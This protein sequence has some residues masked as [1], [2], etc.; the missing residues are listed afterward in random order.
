MSSSSTVAL[1]APAPGWDRQQ[2]PSAASCP[3]LLLRTWPPAHPQSW[4][5]AAP[6]REWQPPAPAKRTIVIAT[7]EEPREFLRLTL[8]DASFSS[9][10]LHPRGRVMTQTQTTCAQRTH[11]KST[12]HG[13]GRRVTPFAHFSNLLLFF[14][15]P[16][17]RLCISPRIP[18]TTSPAPVATAACSV[19]M[20]RWE[21]R[22][23]REQQSQQ[24]T[25]CA[26]V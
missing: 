1:S 19:S 16:A 6:G 13:A 24:K 14:S 17:R 8:A 25:L 4:W 22:S 2:V 5:I 3:L 11:R 10:R 21:S 7:L 26:C 23:A 12:S 9:S 20:K 15:S 18:Q